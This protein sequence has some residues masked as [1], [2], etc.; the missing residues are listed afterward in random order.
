MFGALVQEEDVDRV[1][2]DG[3]DDRVNRLK[4]YHLSS[5]GTILDDSDERHRRPDLTVT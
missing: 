3:G 1:V 4:G 5:E 2:A